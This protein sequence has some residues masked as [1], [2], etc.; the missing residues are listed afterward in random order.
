M[1]GGGGQFEN[2]QDHQKQNFP[3]LFIL[4]LNGL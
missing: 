3:A 2:I 4:A 1:M